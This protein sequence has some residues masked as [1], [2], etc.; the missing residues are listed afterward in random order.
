VAENQEGQARHFTTFRVFVSA[1][2]KVKQ[3]IART[4]KR[5]AADSQ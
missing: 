3:Q 1:V 5:F 2:Q 4:V